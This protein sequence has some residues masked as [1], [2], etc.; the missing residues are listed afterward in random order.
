MVGRGKQKK[1]K[2]D[3]HFESSIHRNAVE[4]MY[5]FK[6]KDAQIETLLS[7]SKRKEIAAQEEERLR[8]RKIII[9]LLDCCRYLCRQ[10]LA[11]RG[12]DDD[13]NG[14]Y[15]QLTL[16]LSRYVPYINYWMNSIFAR[17]YQVSYLSSRSQNEFIQLFGSEVR[18]IIVNEVKKAEIYSLAADTTPDISHKDQISLI[19]RYVDETFKV[20]E[21][22]VMIS[23]ISGKTGSEFAAKVVDM[24]QQLELPTSGI[25]FQCYD[26][27]ASMSGIYN[28]AQAKLSE[29]LGRIIPYIMC[30]GHKGNLCVEHA[31]KESVVIATF[32]DTL[33]R[34]YNFFTKSTGR[35]EHLRE[36]IGKMEEG[37]MMKNLSVTRW[38]GRASSITAV[39]ASYEVLLTVLGKICNSESNQEILMTAQT[40]LDALRD[41]NFYF[42]LIF[43]KNILYKMKIVNLEVQEIQKNAISAVETIE[44]TKT[45]FERIRNDDLQKNNIIDI[46]VTNAKRFDIDPFYEFSKKYRFNLEKH[47]KDVQASDRDEIIEQQLMSFY[48][49]IMNKILDRFIMDLSDIIKY[50]N[51]IILPFKILLPSNIQNCT[52]ED[53]EILCNTFRNDIKTA[54]TPFSTVRRHVFR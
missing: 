7:K 25:R 9:V 22:L 46:A 14:N 26:T 10:C 33:Q 20:Y 36:S 40:L 37:L 38:I 15:R 1:G 8:N 32:F 3:L 27:T 50:M 6:N 52:V 17:P 5:V 29:I 54:T 4:K 19:I 12:G 16:L 18:S 51:D 34:L 42:S 53:A 30:L 23:E 24:L 39:W 41:V 11:F 28:G 13:V 21:R 31:C 44:E 35:C 47:L 45:E 48:R 49:G 43:M 2:I